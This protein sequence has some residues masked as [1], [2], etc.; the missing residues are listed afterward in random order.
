MQQLGAG[1]Q[2]HRRLGRLLLLLALL[3]QPL[4]HPVHITFT[5]RLQLGRR[6]LQHGGIKTQPAGNRQGIAAAGDAPLQ[7]IG[8]GEGFHIEGHR[9]ILKARI[10]VLER[11]E[12]AEVGS[13]DREPGPLGQLTQQ[14][15]RQGRTLGGIGAGPHLIEQHQGS[16]ALG[17]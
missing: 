9:G 5:T 7:A 15:R 10:G 4:N 2:L 12:L 8:G 16:A 13:G 6:R 17:S 11:L 3:L 14:R 1:Q